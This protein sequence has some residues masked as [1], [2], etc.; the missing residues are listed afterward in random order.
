MNF[1]LAY[2]NCIA[3]IDTANK[4]TNFT[5]YKFTNPNEFISLMLSIVSF[6]SYIKKHAQENPELAK[7][8]YLK[9]KELVTKHPELTGL[10]DALLVDSL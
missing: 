8:C 3:A 4:I 1:D 9:I 7:E 5:I 10:N 6:Y 2:Q